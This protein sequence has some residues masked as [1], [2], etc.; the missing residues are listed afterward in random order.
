[1]Y[2]AY[3]GL[4]RLPFSDEAARRSL[5][6][7]P[8]HAEALARLEFLVEQH[9]RLGLLL[10]PAG[11]GKSL[12]LAESARRI[13][14]TGAALACVPAA[15]AEERQLLDALAIGWNVQETGDNCSTHWRAVLDRLE[16]LRLESIPAV[17][18]LD[19]LDRAGA[20]AIAIVERLMSLSDVPLTLIAAARPATAN[21]LGGRLL[22]QADLRIDLSPWTE[23]ETRDYLQTSLIEAGRQQAVFNPAAIR[24]LFELSGGAPRRV[25]QLA[26]LALLAGAGQQLV[27]VDADTLDAVQEELGMVK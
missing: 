3:W 11:S 5:A 27:Q 9:S 23:D 12:V 26:Q 17:A 6:A 16:E 20:A 2:Q 8:V 19:D 25:N 10:G 15:A 1:M 18:L 22:E 7:S 21:R 4:S 14:R 13:A 24:R